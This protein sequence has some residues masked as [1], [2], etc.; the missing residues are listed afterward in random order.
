ME[1][2]GCTHSRGSKTDLIPITSRSAFVPPPPPE[3]PSPAERLM[4]GALANRAVGA[5]GILYIARHVGASG[6]N[7]TLDTV[8]LLFLSLGILL[9]PSPASVL[10]ADW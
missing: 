9:H 8:N 2:R 6:M 7:L 10:K 3:H 1:T 5:L 4:H